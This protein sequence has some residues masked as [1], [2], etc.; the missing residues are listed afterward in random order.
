MARKFHR[1][2]ECWQCKVSAVMNNEIIGPDEPI[3]E[4]LGFRPIL[5]LQ[6][7]SS[8]LRSPVS[9]HILNYIDS[10]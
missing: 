5:I 6:E 8:I 1:Q 4:L 2:D 9:P 7:I 10:T 3:V